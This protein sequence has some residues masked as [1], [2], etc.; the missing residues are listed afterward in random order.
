MTAV[1]LTERDSKTVS[2]EAFSIL[3]SPIHRR[4]KKRFRFP[5]ITEYYLIAAKRLRQRVAAAVGEIVQVGAEVPSRNASGSS[6]NTNPRVHFTPECNLFG[7]IARSDD[8]TCAPAK[9][10]SLAWLN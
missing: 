8:E 9:H 3:S 10:A 7:T 2:F 1:R 5:L 6:S 4:Q